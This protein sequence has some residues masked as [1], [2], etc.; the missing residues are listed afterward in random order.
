MNDHEAR[1]RVEMRA[2]LTLRGGAY[3]W[4]DQP[5]GET[6]QARL[7]DP[8]RLARNNWWVEAEPRPF[9][10]FRQTGPSW[11][12]NLKRFAARGHDDKAAEQQSIAPK[13]GKDRA[14]GKR[15]A[16]RDEGG[17]TSFKEYLP[18]PGDN[19]HVWLADLATKLDMNLPERVNWYGALRNYVAKYKPE[20]KASQLNQN[21]LASL[22]QMICESEEEAA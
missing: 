19:I 11:L 3:D 16:G 13:T 6:D 21:V 18:K 2:A 10:V 5:I 1:K 15:K 14:K 9:D 17:E 8:S 22:I 4:K 20:T 12:D 7:T